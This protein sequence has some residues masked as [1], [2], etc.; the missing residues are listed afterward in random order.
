MGFLSPRRAPEPTD[1]PLQYTAGLICHASRSDE[2]ICIAWMSI[3][4]V[5][6]AVALAR[7]RHSGR[8]MHIIH[9]VGYWCML[10]FFVRAQALIVGGP[11]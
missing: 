8:W 1:D 9:V 11:E 2:Y 3:T 7:L 10:Y 5:T 6:V 4:A